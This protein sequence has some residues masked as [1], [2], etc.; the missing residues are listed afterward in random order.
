MMRWPFAR[1]CQFHRQ[2]WVLSHLTNHLVKCLHRRA[3]QKQSFKHPAIRCATSYFFFQQI[4]IELFWRFPLSKAG[5][6][7]RHHTHSLAYG[8]FFFIKCE[9]ERGVGG[10]AEMRRRKKSA[11][12]E[13]K[14]TDEERV[15]VYRLRG[16]V[17]R[18][19]DVIDLRWPVQVLRQSWKSPII[20]QHIT[21]NHK[22]KPN[23]LPSSRQPLVVVLDPQMGRLI[24]VESGRGIHRI[25]HKVK[26]LT[27]QIPY[28]DHFLIAFLHYHLQ[29]RHCPCKKN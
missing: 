1:P 13:R 4:P 11:N 8:S 12:S 14:H 28:F 7:T 27:F 24:N 5:P 23:H 17:P 20:S 6:A 16:V 18:R 22:K 21:Q 26:H 25:H 9:R 2:G 3:I 19:N 29:V 15:Y 10:T